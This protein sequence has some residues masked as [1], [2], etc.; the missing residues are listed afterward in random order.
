[1]KE[2]SARFATTVKGGDELVIEM[3]KMGDVDEDEDG[4]GEVRFVARVEGRKVCLKNGR[5]LVRM[6]PKL[7]I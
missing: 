1:M 6:A 2:F 5:A 7:E 4:W 3:W